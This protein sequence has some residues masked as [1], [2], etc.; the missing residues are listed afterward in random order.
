MLNKKNGV[1][2]AFYCVLALILMLTASAC[3]KSS[4]D[5]QSPAS[6]MA[7]A[8]RPPVSAQPI[9]WASDGIAS[10]NEYTQFQQIGNLQVFSRLDEDAVCIALRAQTAGYI[11]MGIRP[12]NKMQGADMIICAL[13][14]NRASISDQYSTGT[15]GPHTPDTQL[16]GTND[17][18]SPS[19]S[20]QNGWATFEFKRKLATSDSRDKELSIGDNQVIWS[21]GSSNDITI[22]HNNRGYGTLTL[23]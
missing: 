12:E 22:H 20:M 6:P 10:D 13:S 2:S 7:T 21:M 8:D 1:R 9:T 5:S 18:I 4:T 23:K 15:F 17:I 16:G 11:A 19:G 14:G 3:S